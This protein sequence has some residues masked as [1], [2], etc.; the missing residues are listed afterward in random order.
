MKAMIIGMLLVP[1]C[2]SV[3]QA[4]DSSTQRRAEATYFAA[5]SVIDGQ[6][7][8]VILSNI[9][10]SAS[11]TNANACPLEVQFVDGEGSPI[12]DPIPVQLKPGAS[13][14]VAASHASKL[15]RTIVRIADVADAAKACT[16]KASVEVFDAQTGTT[17]AALAGGPSEAECNAPG[18]PAS[19]I[20][21]KNAPRRGRLNAD[22]PATLGAASKK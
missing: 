8:R 1:I 6:G 19:P 14:A 10:G 20:A 17:F 4:L 22:L 15:V 9:S 16:I 2:S 11:G 12:D 13:A 3:S 7:V 18:V 5:V 21:R